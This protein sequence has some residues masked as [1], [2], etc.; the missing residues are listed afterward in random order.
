MV[1]HFFILDDFRLLFLPMMTSLLQL[2]DFDW[3]AA[4]CVMSYVDS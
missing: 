4:D 2:F 3:M 1:G